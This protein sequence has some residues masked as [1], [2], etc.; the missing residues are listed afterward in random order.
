M[1]FNDILKGISKL[2]FFISLI[3]GAF[4][5]FKWSGF[6]GFYGFL[7]GAF[8]AFLIKEYFNEYLESTKAVL[9]E[10]I[11]KRSKK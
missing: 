8:V 6:K 5:F 10:N 9:E 7:I 11:D 1:N 3:V 2:I 4:L